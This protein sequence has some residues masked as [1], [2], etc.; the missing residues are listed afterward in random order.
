MRRQERG[1][2]QRKEEKKG[3]ERVGADGGGEW[4]RQAPGS[5]GGLFVGLKSQIDVH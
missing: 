5:Q 1:G 2:R 4:E 3:K